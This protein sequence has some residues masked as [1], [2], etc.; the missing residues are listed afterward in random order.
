[1]SGDSGN[2]GVVGVFGSDV[3]ASGDSLLGRTEY[4]NWHLFLCKNT[5]NEA[6]WMYL[7][8][9]YGALIGQRMY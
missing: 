6:D 4:D 8:S 5:V 7:V 2:R 3:T 1:M 9:G